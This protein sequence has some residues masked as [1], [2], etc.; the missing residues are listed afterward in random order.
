MGKGE[1]IDLEA[2]FTA[3]TPLEH[4]QQGVAC[5]AYAV[6]APKDSHEEYFHQRLADN[7]LAAAQAGILVLRMLGDMEGGGYGER[8]NPERAGW[9]EALGM[10][11]H[12]GDIVPAPK[13]EPE[14]D[15]GGYAEPVEAETVDEAPAAGAGQ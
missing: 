4:Y 1:L 9:L 13:P 15:A 14:V 3:L 7:H 8:A 10:M 11:D 12:E 2:D 5:M 6:K